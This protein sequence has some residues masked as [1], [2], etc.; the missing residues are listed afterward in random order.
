MALLVRMP[1]K[2]LSDESAILSEWHVHEGD[3]VKTGDVLFSIET[4]KATFDVES[5]AEGTVRSEARREGEEST[6]RA[7]AY[8]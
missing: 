7:A 5:E 6:F 1:P 4:G 2:G 8:H 3:A